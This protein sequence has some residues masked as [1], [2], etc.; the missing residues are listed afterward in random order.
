MIEAAAELFDCPAVG[1]EPHTTP[2]KNP[3]L[4][5]SRLVSTPVRW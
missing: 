5:Y 2:R 3:H 1:A 4:P